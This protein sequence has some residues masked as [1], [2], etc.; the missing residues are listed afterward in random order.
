MIYLDKEARD[1][2]TDDNFVDCGNE[3]RNQLAE[4]YHEPEAQELYD[5]I[6]RK[7]DEADSWA[8]VPSEAYGQL[9]E[10]CGVEPVQEDEDPA[11]FL[12]RCVSTIKE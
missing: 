7:T 6:K 12:E 4:A 2:I 1:Y 9:A 5:F 11:D 10:L 8:A 3:I